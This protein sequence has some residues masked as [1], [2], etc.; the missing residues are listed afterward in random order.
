MLGLAGDLGAVG[1]LSKKLGAR[2][3]G[4]EG[5]GGEGGAGR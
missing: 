1:A 4:R 5:G 2:G 3:G